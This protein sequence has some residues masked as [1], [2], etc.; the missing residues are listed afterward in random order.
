ML[1]DQD[2]PVEILYGG[3][4]SPSNT[5]SWMRNNVMITID[6]VKYTTASNG[7]RLQIHSVIGSDEASYSCRYED[8]QGQL[9]TDDS[10][11]L[12]VLGELTCW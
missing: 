10:S 1:V 12:Y 9:Q 4:V 7:A 11:C 3:G 8:N 2:Q 6:F 5:P